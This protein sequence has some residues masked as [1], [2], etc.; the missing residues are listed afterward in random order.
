MCGIAGFC[1]FRK[2]VGP[3]SL[4]SMTEALGHRGPDGSGVYFKE[5][6]AYNIGLA[7]RRL[8]VIDLTDAG[9]QPM[10][11]DC[12]QYIITFNGEIY[13]FEELR[14]QLKSKG[15]TF[16]GHSDTEVIVHLFILYGEKCVDMLRG[17]FAFA[18]L[19]FRRNII[20][21]ARDRMGVKPFYYYFDKSVFYFASELSAFF[22]LEGFSKTISPEG[23]KDYI[24]RGYIGGEKTIFQNVKKLKKGTTLTLDLTTAGT[25]TEVYWDV[26][27]YYSLPRFTFSYN[28]FIDELD[29]KLCE[30][31]S[32]RLVADVPI[33]IFLSSGYDSSLLAAMLVKRLGATPS[34]FTL[35]F[36]DPDFDESSMA[37]TIAESLNT[38]HHEFICSDRDALQMINEWPA[39]YSEPFSDPSAIPTLL[40]SRLASRD[41]KVVMSADGGDEIFFGYNRYR[42]FISRIERVRWLRR[43][44]G[45]ERLLSITG[46]LYQGILSDDIDNYLNE[47][48][49]HCEASRLTAPAFTPAP[50]AVH[51]RTS[52]IVDYRDQIMLWDINHYLVDD[53]LVKIDRATMA[54]GIEG[55]EPLLDHKLVEFMAR[56][57]FPFK[58]KDGALKSPIK[59]LLPRY[60]D[61]QLVSKEKKGFSPPLGHWMRSVFRSEYDDVTNE[62]YLRNQGIFNPRL[63]EVVSSLR[64]DYLRT[65]VQWSVL[66]FQKWFNR[67]M[68]K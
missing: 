2:I 23:L 53:I 40:V 51:S 46:S 52:G 45:A 67:W 62:T 68:A 21:C 1:D 28:D 9:A 57:P 54:Y 43:F 39:Y 61:P 7:H 6:D 3:S 27:A 20:F 16:R 37:R 29:A 12:G 19:D 59:S 65:R 66:M 32:Y 41:I 49:K 38:N 5:T 15:V 63:R 60:I 25:V 64:P 42:N 13:N 56:V 35:G 24:E 11:S 36:D 4:K 44:P 31:F 22:G 34:T 26:D 55:R 33:G 47:V 10:A 58:F 14:A 18:I 48:N 17:M 8:A 30:A 50:G